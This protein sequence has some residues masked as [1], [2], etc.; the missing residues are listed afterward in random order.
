M[1]TK[2][3]VKSAVFCPHIRQPTTIPEFSYFFAIILEFRHRGAR[4]VDWHIVSPNRFYLFSALFCLLRFVGAMDLYV[5][6]QDIG[7]NS[8]EFMVPSLAMALIYIVLVALISLGVKLMER[9]LRKS[10]RRN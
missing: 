2:Y 7:T 10:D 9:S 4:Y 1:N 5:A 3:F 6:F 8:Y